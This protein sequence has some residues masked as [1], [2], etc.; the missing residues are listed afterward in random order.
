ML[1]PGLVNFYLGSLGRSKKK[2][3]NFGLEMV[4]TEV[5]E[6]NESSNPSL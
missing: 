1:L 5:K 4:H 2:R 3:E 6:Y